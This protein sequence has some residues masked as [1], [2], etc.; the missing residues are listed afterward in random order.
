M[1]TAQKQKALAALLTYK[2]QEE[3][4]KAA[5]ISVRTIITYLNDPE[6]RREYEK[7]AGKLVE[8]ATREIQTGMS[9]AIFVLRSILES[10]TA[11]DGS[12]ISAAR[13]VLE[14]GLRMTETVDLLKRVEALED[15]SHDRRY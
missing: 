8:K 14:F 1:L 4:A 5:G 6:F 2:T 7:A 13:A 9:D 12:K 15:Q 3:A 11:T 10:M